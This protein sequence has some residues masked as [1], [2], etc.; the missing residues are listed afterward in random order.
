MYQ[1]LSLWLE[2][3][4]VSLSRADLYTSCWVFCIVYSYWNS[5]TFSRRYKQWCQCCFSIDWCWHSSPVWSSK[6]NN[7][8]AKVYHI[9]CIAMYLNQPDNFVICFTIGQHPGPVGH[10]YL[11]KSFLPSDFDGYINV[12]KFWISHTVSYFV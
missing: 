1:L 6:P 9:T 11:A 7:Q 12:M 3:S 5:I 2:I 8:Y 10:A 4:S